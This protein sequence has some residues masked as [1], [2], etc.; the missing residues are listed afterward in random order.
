MSAAPFLI[1][2]TGP[3]G[4][5][6]STIAAMLGDLGATI[7]DADA[8][9]RA[10]T[11]SGEPTLPAIRGRFGHAVFTA[12]GSLDRAVLARIVFG[13][14]AALADL[15]AIVHPEVRR[16]V[17]ASL[18]AARQAGALMVVVEAIKLV[19]GGLAERCD[20]VWLV[21]CGESDQRSRLALRDMEPDEIS[22]RLAS[23][24]LDLIAR[25]EPDATRR[26]DTSGSPEQTR[27]LVE[28]ALA[29]ALAPLLL[30]EGRQG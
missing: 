21:A 2:L 19:E 8:L 6:K 18:Q 20:E 1:G 25:L 7:V 14:R 28:D 16:R 11:G 5:G 23:Q 27:Q 9:A 12:D 30:G 4:C 13:D 15:E 24:G 22:R 29:D 17:A 10:A 26:I 3:I